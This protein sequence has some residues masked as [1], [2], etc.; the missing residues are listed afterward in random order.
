ATRFL[1][2]HGA[3][4]VR[5]DAP[6]FDEIPAVA[7]DGGFGK[8]STVLDLR[9]AGDRDA[10]ERLVSSADVV[11]H[12]YRPGALSG[13]GYSTA[14]LASLRP[15][16]IIGRLSAYGPAGPWAHRRGFRRLGQMVSGIAEEGRRAAGTEHPVPLPCQALDHAS[17][18]LLALGVLIGLRRRH[19]EGQSWRIAVSLARTAR[20]LDDLGRVEGGRDTPEPTP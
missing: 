14:R 11:V 8:R 17:G 19:R 12:G 18:Y 1:A 16:L 15:G 3:D 9:S 4:V 20:W 10:F 5:V 7:I 6:G 2:G 13:L